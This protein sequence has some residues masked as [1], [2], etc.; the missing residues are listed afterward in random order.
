MSQ[1]N[2]LSETTASR[3]Q[4]WI[5]ERWK[6]QLDAQLTEAR[7]RS[8]AERVAALESRLANAVV[9]ADDEI[10]AGRVQFGSLVTV[11]GIEEE[12]EQSF[13]IVSD[14]EAE[15]SRG[16]L[17]AGTPL[18]TALFGAQEG[19]VVRVLLGNGSNSDYEVTH[20]RAP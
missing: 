8:A 7:S 16:L 15:I 12:E 9:V 18:A 2:L 3:Y 17:G 11:F 4:N 6:Q 5:T 20:V 19:Q 10:M 14:D 1:P 13:Q